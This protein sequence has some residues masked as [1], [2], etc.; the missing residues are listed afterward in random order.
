M[1]AELLLGLANAT[2]MLDAESI[3]GLVANLGSKGN[4]RRLFSILF[5]PAAARLLY[6]SS[7][8]SSDSLVL[9]LTVLGLAVFG[10]KFDQS[11]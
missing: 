2:F 10:F 8:F 4:N 3:E 6:F 7:S 9:G 11:I 1:Y 5:L